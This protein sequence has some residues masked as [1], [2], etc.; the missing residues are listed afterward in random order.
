MAGQGGHRNR[1]SRVR[2]REA[3]DN[4]DDNTT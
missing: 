4:L 1:A 2:A 3:R